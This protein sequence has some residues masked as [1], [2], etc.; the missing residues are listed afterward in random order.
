L[1]RLFILSI[2]TDGRT[3]LFAAAEAGHLECAKLLVQAGAD[4]DHV[5]HLGFSPLFS[6]AS[7]GHTE[8]A[9]LLLREGADVDRVD[10]RDYTP[11]YC[12]SMAKS[13]ECVRLL[14]E[15]GAT[16]NNRT[17][18]PFLCIF[19]FT[20]RPDGLS[21]LFPCIKHEQYDCLKYLC[22]QGAQTGV[23]RLEGSLVEAA[24][25][26]GLVEFIRLLLDHGAS[27]ETTGACNSS[28]LVYFLTTLF[29]LLKRGRPFL[30]R[31]KRAISLVLIC[32]SSE[33][34][35]PQR[36]SCPLGTT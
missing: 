9:R 10:D 11:I 22:D 31:P 20:F 15:H 33:A 7:A 28:V 26:K 6:A 16:L 30:S 18:P 21:P 36:R 34:Q 8:I 29:P 3:A 13:L 1:A 17:P 5:A 35:T 27:V 23:S 19:N 14:T 2:V 32:C 24:A 4:A 25:R 12:A